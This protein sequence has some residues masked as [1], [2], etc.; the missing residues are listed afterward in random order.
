MKK[1][2]PLIALLGLSTTLSANLYPNIQRN[3]SSQKS[4]PYY[5]QSYYNQTANPTEDVDYSETQYYYYQNPQ[6]AQDQNYNQDGWTTESFEYSQNVNPSYYN[7][8]AQ[9]QGATSQGYYNQGTQ[10]QSAASQGFNQNRVITQPS[11]TYNSTT[12]TNPSFNQNRMTPNTANNGIQSSYFSTD[13]STDTTIRDFPQDR[14]TTPFDNELNKKIRDKVS[15]GW[16]W[17]NHKGVTLNT[18]NGIVTLDGSI[19][20]RDEEK[21]LVDKIS[22]I[23]GVK[24]VNSNLTI[25]K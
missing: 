3:T 19:A 25:Q 16:L 7:Q 9:S 5:N 8:G 12:G 14:A 22:K 10:S 6:N 21:K 20:N 1:I 13:A 4:F 17:N 15:S 18:N 23:D 11:T 2:L 24:S